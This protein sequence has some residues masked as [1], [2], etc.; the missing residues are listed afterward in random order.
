MSNG[1][2]YSVGIEPQMPGQNPSRDRLASQE[3]A[4][5]MGLR[6]HLRSL[7]RERIRDRRAI[8]GA[9]MLAEL[10][11]FVFPV[12]VVVASLVAEFI[13][14]LIVSPAAPLTFHLGIG[15]LAAI[16]LS[17]V[18]SQTSVHAPAAIVRTEFQARGVLAAASMRFLLLLC[19]FY[20]L[21]TSYHI[22]RVSFALLYVLT[23]I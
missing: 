9:A 20:H 14:D 17:L 3:R 19:D 22:S 16:I 23:I 1:L 12:A 5:G 18:Q 2:G 13:H 7:P 4:P 10:Q 6:T 21:K 8:G 11:T 15:L